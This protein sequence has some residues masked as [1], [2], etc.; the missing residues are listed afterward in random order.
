MLCLP[1]FQN[2]MWMQTTYKRLIFQG[3]GI[4]ALHVGNN[5]ILFCVLVG[6]PPGFGRRRGSCKA[7]SQQAEFIS[8]GCSS[9]CLSLALEA[10]TPC[11]T[12]NGSGE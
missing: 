4:E 7:N 12:L 5:E 10:E 9:A 1:L 3:N 6:S 11:F 8:A 2:E